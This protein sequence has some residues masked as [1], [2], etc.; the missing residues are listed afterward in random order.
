MLGEHGA[1][2][3]NSS[4]F[5]SAGTKEYVRFY[6]ALDSGATWLDQGVANLTANDVPTSATGGRRLEYA[7]SVPCSPP[8]RWCKFPN[9]ILARAILSWNH[10][11]PANSANYVP[12]GQ[13][14][15]HPHSSQR[16]LVAQMARRPQA[17]GYS[18][19][20]ESR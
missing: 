13:Y 11:P 14:P 18:A 3:P 6:I 19:G 5:C 17:R 2:I 20:G 12:V 7:V 16:D 15:R 1:S 10:I 8:R 4:F 9:V